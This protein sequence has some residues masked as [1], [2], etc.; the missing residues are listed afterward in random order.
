[1]STGIIIAIIVVVLLV[2]LAI[3]VFFSPKARVKR[4]ERELGKRRDETI[5]QHREEAQTRNER[6]SE[7]DERARVAEAEAERARVEAQRQR[8]EAQVHEARAGVHERGLADHELI[9]DNE[10]E[11]FAGTSAAEV[12]SHEDSSL[13]QPR[14]VEDRAAQD[15]TV[16]DRAG[17]RSA[18]DRTDAGAE[19]APVEGEPGASGEERPTEQRPA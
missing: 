6:A 18:Q 10:R 8:A 19:R 15:G 14:P 17:E 2:V 1:M 13:E 5:E 7:I 4:R 12:P 16:G 9:S 11:R 3:A